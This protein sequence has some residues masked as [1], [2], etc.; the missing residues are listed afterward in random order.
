MHVLILPS[1]YPNIN[2]SLSGVFFKEQAEAIAGKHIKVGCIAINE[3]AFRYVL[4][5][6]E[7]SF[8]YT[9]ELKNSVQTMSLVYPSINRLKRIRA[10]V[11]KQI[12][13]TLFKTYVKKHG[14]P[15]I[16][17]LHSFLYGDLVIWIKEKYSI[18]YIVTEHSSAFL[19]GLLSN[20][21]LDLAYDV[22]NNAS[23]NIVVSEVFRHFL[24]REFNVDFH[25]IPN[26]VDTNF[27]TL[28]SNK[29]ESDFTFVNIAS[30]DKKKNQD[31]L[32]EA[33]YKAFGNHKKVKLMIIGEGEEYDNLNQRIKTLGL[34]SQV[35]LYGRA[36]RYEVRELL[37][38]SSA[39]VLSSEV[40]TFGVVLIEAMACGLPVLSTKCGGPESIIVNK[41][42]GELVEQTASSL[43][44]GMLTVYNG[45][46][47]SDFIR[48]YA[49]KKFS[50]D[51]ISKKLIKVYLNNSNKIMV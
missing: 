44:K 33:F 18:N 6:K 27:F 36:N 40:E 14:K 21:E 1:W 26:M 10:Y 4:N 5:G 41:K 49:I 20:K 8:L 22:F 34:Q 43:S 2:S 16:V 31:M 32:L 9:D 37:H 15:D 12:F 45:S 23:Y 48:D 13:K 30:L 47:D 50:S 11:R 28:K 42:I 35:T 24:K 7:K 29:K 19:R 25:F 3:S 38:T 51:V 46:Y 39:C 17:H